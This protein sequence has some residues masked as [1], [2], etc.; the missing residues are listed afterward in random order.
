MISVSN[1]PDVTVRD[2]STGAVDSLV[3]DFGNGDIISGLPGQSY[4]YT[5]PQAGTYQLCLRVYGFGADTTCAD[6]VC[7]MVLATEA[8][9]CDE[10]G[11]T[12]AFSMSASRNVATFTDQSTGNIDEL[13]WD[14]GDGT[15][16]TSAAGVTLTHV[17]P[18]PSPYQVCLTAIDTLRSGDVCKSTDCRLLVIK[19]E[20]GGGGGPTSVEN[21]NPWGLTLAPNP[22]QAGFWLR[23]AQIRT[24]E[25][26]V[27]DAQGRQV[28]Q[29]SFRAESLLIDTQAWS[30]GLYLIRFSDGKQQHSLT[31]WK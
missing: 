4:P 20:S 27:F 29:R 30:R 1:G 13:S 21:T 12:A 6:S 5:Y 3:F 28:Q 26:L 8:F 11:L 16:L 24:L 25:I 18:G 23:Q 10:V 22:G 2:S 15:S 31:W 14:F 9:P 7:V 17:Y 19:E